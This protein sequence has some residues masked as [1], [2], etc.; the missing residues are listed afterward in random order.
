MVFYA[1]TWLYLIL[2]I[3][4]IHEAVRFSGGNPLFPVG[5]G[6]GGEAP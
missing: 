1:Q 5:G 6:G 2:S 3:F 4:T